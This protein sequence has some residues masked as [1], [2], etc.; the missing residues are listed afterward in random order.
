MRLA[1][2]EVILIGD[3]Y[4]GKTQ[5]VRTLLSPAK[6]KITIAN[7]SP[8][9]ISQASTQALEDNTLQIKAD[10]RAPKRLS[11]KWIDT[12]GEWNRSEW[13]NDP[14]RQTDFQKYQVQ[15]KTANAVVLL[16]RPYRTAGKVK[17]S[18]KTII[19]KNEIPTELQWCRRFERW[20]RFINSNCSG[21]RHL[22]LCLSKADLFCDVDNEATV[23]DSKGWL[24]RSYYV[25]QGF[26]PKNKLF[27]ESLQ[28][29]QAG[30]IRFFIVS[31]N[32]RT[33]LELPWLSLATH[34]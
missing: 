10:L 34:L 3:R 12:P 13:Q 31:I 20:A 28:M 5:S 26:F 15:L 18:D 32:N 16:L 30:G 8:E 24:E 22:N 6:G 29:I 7:L 14:D 19:E 27:Q 33:L 23:I 17:I 1:V 25:K 21:V 2:S 4:V 9:S 11:V